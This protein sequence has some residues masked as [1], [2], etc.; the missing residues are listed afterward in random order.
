MFTIPTFQN[1]IFCSDGY[2]TLNS[3]DNGVAGRLTEIIE[4]DGGV[5]E[6]YLDNYCCDHRLNV[7][8]TIAFESG[9]GYIIDKYL[10]E[11]PKE[12]NRNALIRYITHYDLKGVM[13]K[14]SRLSETRFLYNVLVSNWVFEYYKEFVN[15]IPLSGVEQNI[16]KNLPNDTELGV[17]S[18]TNPIFVGIVYFVNMLMTEMKALSDWLQTDGLLFFMAYKRIELNIKNL[19]DIRISIKSGDFKYFKKYLYCGN[20]H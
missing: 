16:S 1:C 6:C 2:M 12:Q 8:N 17:V 5:V 9:F 14:V 19:F 4:R 3:N 11:I 10:N 15:F 20:M 13:N 7:S 18:F